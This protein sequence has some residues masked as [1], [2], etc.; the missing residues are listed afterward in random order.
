MTLEAIERTAVDLTRAAGEQALAAFRTTVALEFKG[1]RKDNLI[2]MREQALLSRELVR[3]DRH[4][5][6]KIDWDAAR[7]DG[8]DQPALAEGQPAAL[9]G[10]RGGERPGGDDPTEGDDGRQRGEEAG[11]AAWN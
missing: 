2:T 8:V 10:G 1:K 6:I 11:T 5:P 3:L 9:R 4:V 7:V